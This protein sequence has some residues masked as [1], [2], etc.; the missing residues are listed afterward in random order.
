[1][2]KFGRHKLP[3]RAD[4]SSNKAREGRIAIQEV[5]VKKG[6][7]LILSIVSTSVGE[8]NIHWNNEEGNNFPFHCYGDNCKICDFGDKS[9]LTNILCVFVPTLRGVRALRVPV[10]N[11]PSSLYI[12]LDEALEDLAADSSFDLKSALFKIENREQGAT[13]T[14]LPDKLSTTNQKIITDFLQ[15]YNADNEDRWSSKLEK[16]LL[17]TIPRLTLNELKERSAWIHSQFDNEPDEECDD[18]AGDIDT[19][20]ANETNV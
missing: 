3:G 16:A 10:S 4:G 11:N 5:W 13:V 8:A 12:A 9:Q 20:D 7:N 14:V 18:G 19:D 6:N 17:D 2:A 15:K 1:M